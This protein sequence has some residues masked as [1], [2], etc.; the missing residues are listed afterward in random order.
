[1]TLPDRLL[2][3]LAA[4]QVP[5]V[6][7]LHINPFVHFVDQRRWRCNLCYRVNELPEEF[8]YDPVSEQI[9]DHISHFHKCAL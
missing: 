5:V 4:P 8:L 1:M 2:H 6:P 9:N 7:D 3:P